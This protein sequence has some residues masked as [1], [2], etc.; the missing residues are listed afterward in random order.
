MPTKK[1]DSKTQSKSST[2]KRDE[3]MVDVLE[4][5]TGAVEALKTTVELIKERLDI[6]NDN[7]N[8]AWERLDTH[9]AKISQISG[10]LGL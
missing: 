2:Q 10:R 4:K 6:V 9:Q 3:V 7:C 1:K 5:L 8:G